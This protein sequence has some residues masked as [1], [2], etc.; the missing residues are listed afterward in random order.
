MYKFPTTIH[1]TRKIYENVKKYE[2]NTSTWIY[3]NKKHPLD[4]WNKRKCRIIKD[5]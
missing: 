2:Q 3:G 4:N 5:F 1:S